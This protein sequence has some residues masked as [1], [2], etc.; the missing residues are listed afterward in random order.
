MKCYECA[1]SNVDH[2]AVA[3]CS[4]CGMGLC[5]DHAH[6]VELNVLPR[7]NQ[8]VTRDAMHILCDGCAEA[9]HPS[10]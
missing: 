4:E 1:Q 6:R 8:W 5:M 10:G 7:S 2:E 9:L 3:V